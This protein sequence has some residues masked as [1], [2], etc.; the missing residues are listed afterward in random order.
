MQRP[1]G[2]Q[3][4]GPP[5]SDSDDHES[6]DG[7]DDSQDAS[8]RDTE[9]APQTT[10]RGASYATAASSASLATQAPVDGQRQRRWLDVALP[11]RR[12][13]G[14]RSLH[15][16]DTGLPLD[17]THR[18][19][20]FCVTGPKFSEGSTAWFQANMLEKFNVY[21]D[22]SP[23]NSILR[24]AWQLV[25]QSVHHRQPRV[26][27]NDTCAIL[28]RRSKDSNGRIVFRHP[29]SAYVLRR[30]LGLPDAHSYEGHVCPE[31]WRPFP[32][33]PSGDSW[34]SHEHDRCECGTRRFYREN[35]KLRPAQRFWRRSLKE[36]IQS[37]FVD[38]N[39]VSRMGAD[40]TWDTKG[41]FWASPYCHCL[42]EAC[43]GVLKEPGDG[44]IALV[45]GG[46]AFLLPS[47][48]TACM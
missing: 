33:I 4:Y 12:V 9:D 34:D 17:D 21:G 6:V 30:M 16:T 43:R 8:S 37:L 40:R 48:A 32:K 28:H 44:R 23:D 2:A 3:D 31:C 1:I 26:S 10:D 24:E 46:G 42:N 14:A 47:T 15:H 13:Q 36:I 35:G 19:R 39:L 38:N 22:A 45:F 25:Y 18:D 11:H 27:L 5:L 20:Y 41:S 29:P 7:S